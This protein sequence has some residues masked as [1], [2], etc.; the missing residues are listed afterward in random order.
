MRVLI[1]KT[2]SMGD[3]IHTLPALTD[4]A[5]AIPGITFDWVVE[6][7]FAE[8]PAWHPQVDRVIPMAWR[9]WRKNMFS[10]ATLSEMRAF[11]RRLRERSYDL[12]IDAQGLV[13]SA[14]F[15]RF[16]KGLH[17]GLDW[18]SARESFAA[19]FYQQTCTVLF[20]QHAVIRARSLF[21]QALKYALPET[22]AD[23]GIDRNRFV[24]DPS[25]HPYLV[26]LHGTTWATKHWPEESWIELAKTASLAGFHIKL[27]WGNPA[28]RER[29]E[30]IAKD[31]N[32]ALVLPR[33]DLV[34]MAKVLAGAKA[35]VAVDTG[36]GHLAA[37]L[38]VPTVS[39]Y[40]PTNPILTGA[41][42]QSQVHMSAKFA[43]APCL[44]KVC[45]YREA[46]PL[47]SSPLYPPCFASLASSSVW[48]ELT[49]LL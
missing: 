2:S 26:F 12:I 18:K 11:R 22:V 21:S 32:G 39:L 49:M 36:L 29:A 5:K 47:T 43:C 8:I 24:S 30:R 33:L 41:L 14:V 19:L 45:T 7:N 3:V 1:V 35:I 6:E 37:A 17:C 48:A 25:V 16:A 10:M 13:K 42:G 38:D 28:E 23:Y 31:C 27:P 20:E 34:G 44:S 40:G 46:S 9:R 4:A 15:S